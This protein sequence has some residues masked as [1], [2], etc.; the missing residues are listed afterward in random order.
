ML[1][2]GDGKIEIIVDEKNNGD[3]SSHNWRPNFFTQTLLALYNKIRVGYVW[4]PPF[5]HWIFGRLDYRAP[6]LLLVFFSFVFFVAT[7]F[8]FVARFA[9]VMIGQQVRTQ[10]HLKR[11]FRV[12]FFRGDFCRGDFIQIPQKSCK[13]SWKLP[14]IQRKFIITH[15]KLKYFNKYYTLTQT[16]TCKWTKNVQVIYQW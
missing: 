14:K 3:G 12:I 13:T 5:G 15:A 9:H 16:F 2:N 1:R 11:F 6:E 10:R 4:S 8:R 7:L